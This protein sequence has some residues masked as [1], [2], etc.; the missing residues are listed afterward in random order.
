MVFNCLALKR[1]EKP[2]VVLQ[3]KT[4]ELP[5]I[6]GISFVY[7]AKNRYYHQTDS[8]DF[9]PEIDDDYLEYP[10]RVSSMPTTMTDRILD[11]KYAGKRA[12]GSIFFFIAAKQFT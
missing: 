10:D 12:V 7:G 11:P 6:M 3:K 5:W 4:L 2:Q 9:L 8:M 1:T